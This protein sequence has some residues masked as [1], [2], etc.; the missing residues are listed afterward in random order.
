VRSALLVL[1]CASLPAYADAPGK[2]SPLKGGAHFQSPDNRALEADDFA[3]PGMLWVTRGEA[4]WTKPAGGA[5]ASCASCHA[6][7]SMRGIAARYPRFDKALGKV[8]NLEQRINACVAGRQ[9]APAHAWESEALLSLTSYV[10]RQSHGMPIAVSIDGPALKVFEAGRKLYTT[11][12]GQLHLAC[13]NCHDANWGKTLLAEPISQ[14]HPEG[15]P[16]YRL[17]WQAL[18]SLERRLRAC[19]F[20]VRAEMPAYGSDD[21]IAL[22]LY[23]GWRAQGLARASPGIRR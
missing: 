8:V 17:E 13:T 10:A 11:R 7:G 18:G 14:G 1:L 2:P 20:G 21:F 16:A 6:E 22:E 3:N 23:L 5:N 4:L 15:W 19:F 12:I 9:R